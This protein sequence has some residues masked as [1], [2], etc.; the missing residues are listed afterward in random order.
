MIR[1]KFGQVPTHEGNSCERI[2]FKRTK[3]IYR[4]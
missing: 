2:G 3:P 1:G 4:F